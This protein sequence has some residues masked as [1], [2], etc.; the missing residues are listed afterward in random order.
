MSEEAHFAPADSTVMREPLDLLCYQRDCSVVR[1][2]VPDAVITPRS[3]EEVAAVLKRASAQ[4]TPVYVRGAGTMYAGGANPHAGGIVLDMTALDRVLELDVA[5]GVVV[6]EPGVRFAALTAQLAPLGLTLGIVP[7]TAPAATIGGAAAAHALGTGSARF[8]SFA[9]EV[10]GLEVA[11]PDGTLLRTGSA[12]AGTVGWFQRFGI[13]PDLTG[14]F[15]GGDATLGVITAIAL[16][17]HPLPACRLT[18]CFGFPDVTAATRF[19]L[20]MQGRELTRN[21]WYAAGYEGGSVRAR[22]LA[23]HPDTDASTLPGFCVGVDFGGDVD[24]VARDEA[25][26]TRICDEVGGAPYPLFDDVYFRHLRNEQI[27]WYGY[28]GYFSRS[29]CVILMGSLPTAGMPAFLATVDTL[30]Q[31]YPAFGWGGAVVVCRRGLH[32]GVLAFYDEA[33]QWTAA[34]A[35]A[36]DA[37]AALVAAGCIPYKTGKLW[38]AQTASFTPWHT[39][40]ARV[41]QTL[42]PAGILSPG[43]LGLTGVGRESGR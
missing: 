32:G 26:L 22:V 37:G 15:L 2:G 41:K 34:E 25:L 9:D 42:D 43:N 1:P 30:R 10:V 4:A 40:L 36:Q 33:T 17:L 18:R 39:V 38:A 28:A 13:G 24:L 20:A 35:A 29:R 14:L 11:L 7:S 27:Y 19:L 31:R 21:V 16:W 12:A 5:R 8:Q 3:R 6:V 23:A